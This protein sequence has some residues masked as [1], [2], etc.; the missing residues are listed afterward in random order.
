[1]DEVL[2]D[3]TVVGQQ[4]FGVFRQAVTPIA[5]AGVVVVGADAWIKPYAVDDL[6]AVQPM[7]GGIGVE[8]VEV[9]DTH[10]QISVG[11]EFDGFGFCGIG[12][13]DGDV[14]LDGTFFKQIGKDFST[15]GA[16]AN[17]DTGRMQVVVESSAFT[18]EF[19]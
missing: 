10:S 13:E 19:W 14:L 1:M 7:G 15:L 9:R 3:I 6:F 2:W 5:K 17:D 11:K 18:Q 8:F 4:L 16:F 12:K